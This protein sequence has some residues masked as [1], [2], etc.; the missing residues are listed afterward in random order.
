MIKPITSIKVTGKRV[1]VRAGFDV[2]LKLNPHKE[3]LQVVDDT[4]VKDILPTLRYLIKQKAKI[5]II[6]H[7]DRPK[8]WE[9]AKSMWPV[10]QDLARLLNYKAV[11]FSDR[12]PDYSVPHV[13][14]L[15][16][17]ITKKDYSQYSKDL[18][19]GDILFL[20]NLRFYAG[21]KDNDAK[22]IKTLATFGDIFV[23][24]AFSV[25]HRKE[26]S[27]YGIAQKLPSYAGVSLMKEISSLNKLLRSPAHPMVLIMGGAKVEDKAATIQHL[28]KHAD[29]ILVGGA[30]G[31][32]FLA[33]AGYETGK[34]RVEDV[35]LAKE[36]LRNYKSKIVLPA[37]VVVAK[38]ESVHARAVDV[39]KVHANEIMQDI[40]PKSVRKFAQFINS[41]KTLV[42]NGPMG[43]I[44][45]K[46]F[47]FGSS[48]IATAFATKSKGAA[49]GVIGGGET[50]QVIDRA[51][52]AEY[53]DHISTG[54]GSML[55]YLAGKKLPGIE[56]L[57]K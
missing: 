4:R 6:S 29:H 32:S 49:F 44:E 42:W 15:T 9:P 38:D 31:N 45:D 18:R 46:K 8:G 26:S 43:V 11:K 34:S 17:D 56:V 52:V 30:L 51:K 48:G 3:T 19:P 23:Q 37:D 5:V 24:D 35:P 22:F 36:L 14:F 39:S 1:V 41:A 47:W 40:G 7:L 28:A 25:V 54:G 13:N 10:A 16:R 20:E 55:E 33:A 12:M 21:E 2:Q 53:I 50:I 57:N 27:V